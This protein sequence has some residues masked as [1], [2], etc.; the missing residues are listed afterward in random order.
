MSKKSAEV[1][2]LGKEAK[3]LKENPVLSLAFDELLT[4]LWEQFLSAQLTD[5][6]VIGIHKQA[7]GVK[8]ARGKLSAYID[9]ATAEIHNQKIDREME[10]KNAR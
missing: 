5:E 1:I 3:D 4:V 2:Q 7:V 10:K 6:E 9:D 8:Y